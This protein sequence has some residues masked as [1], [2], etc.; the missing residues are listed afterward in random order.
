MPPPRFAGPQLGPDTFVSF[1]GTPLPLTIWPASDSSSTTREPW[2]VILALH[3]MNDYAQAWAIAGPYWAALGITTYAYDQRGFGR[4]P[5]RGLWAS[6]ALMNEDVRTACKLLRA[7]HPGAVLA[8]VGESMG[9]A[10]AITAFA[11]SE[12][13]AADRAVLLS[14]AVWGW[15]EQPLVNRLALWIV[16]HGDPST[17]LSPPGWVYRRHL[18]SDNVEV[19]RRMGRDRNMVFETRADAAYGLMGLMQ[20]AS[21]S[22]AHMAVP[23]LYC[24]GMHDHLIPRQAAFHAASQ[25]GALDRT[26]FYKDG[27][28]LLNRDLHAEVV[29]KDVAGFIRDPAAAF[30]SGAPSI[31]KAFG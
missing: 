9:A 22:I 25:L 18:P 13:P 3:G 5:K 10:V 1:D 17:L 16:A 8:V 14:P 28:H 21:D 7:R 11:S 20:D 23:T 24:Y 27:W 2:A 31:P 19:L 12:P 6:E 15:S 4:G 30:P 29:L 26:A